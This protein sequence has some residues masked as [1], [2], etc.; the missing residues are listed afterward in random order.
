MGQ[1]RVE[2]L[3]EGEALLRQGGWRRCLHAR[4]MG[5]SMPGCSCWCIDRDDPYA[6]DAF[7]TRYGYVLEVPHGDLSPPSVFRFP[8]Y[9]TE[10]SYARAYGR[11]RD[12]VERSHLH[13][14]HGLDPRH[15]E[16]AE[17]DGGGRLQGG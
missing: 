7:V 10:T 8:R 1:E 16:G 11:M 15:V 2:S 3:E 14:A 6:P 5:T 17:A 4:G 12:F 9:R 13:I